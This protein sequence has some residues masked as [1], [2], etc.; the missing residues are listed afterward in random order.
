M[1]NELLLRNMESAQCI[2]AAKKNFIMRNKVL[3]E[4]HS[5]ILICHISDMHSDIKR[6]ENSMFYASYFGADFIVHTGDTV[7]WDMNSDYKYFAETAKTSNVPMYN[8]IGNHETFRGK[9]KTT[10]QWLHQEL[11]SELRDI[12]SPNNRGYYYVDFEKYGLRFIT[13][14][15]YDYDAPNAEQHRAAYSISQEQCEWLVEVL[16]NAAEK[17][18][19]V[20]I[21]SHECDIPI[22][23]ASNTL[24]FC[25]RFEPY[26]WGLPIPHEHV[27]A[28]IVDAFKHGKELKIDF[29]WHTTG[30]HVSINDKFEKAGEFVCYLN[31]H[32]HADYA[33]FVPGF[34]DQF[35]ICMPCSGC[36]PEGYHNIGE[37]ISDLPRIPDTVTE[38]C[39]NFYT[40]DREKKT[41]SIV[42]VGAAVNDLLEV[43]R[44]LQ[45][46]Y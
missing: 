29:T 37:E 18:Y 6:F 45:I 27:I 11:L 30:L 25:Q 41:I 20:M 36:Y 10:N 23:A 26:P 3:S 38:D 5:Q 34:P 13:L 43:R 9:E 32:R 28:D 31:G 12:H 39:V 7:E 1:M 42:R 35:S 4:S 33:G 22:P 2:Y 14:N 15:D 8:C 19:A 44:S 40:I 17:D 21:A 16:K 24:G 46:N